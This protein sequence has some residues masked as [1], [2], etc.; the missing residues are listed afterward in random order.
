MKKIMI[1][2][3][4]LALLFVLLLAGGGVWA[5]SAFFH[6]EPLTETELAE[7]TPDW[8]AVTRGNWSPWYDAGD[9]TTE[10]NPV[11]SYNA[12]VASIPEGDRAWPALVDAYYAHFDLL[13]SEVIMECNGTVPTDPERWAL[14]EPVLATPESD[15]LLDKLLRAFDRPEMG[16]WLN[17]S[18]GPYEHAAMVK[19]AAAQP[20]PAPGERAFYQPGPLKFDREANNELIN[21]WMPWLSRQRHFANFMRSKAAYE[22]ERGDT[23]MFVET[24]TALLRSSDM[25]GDIP[26]YINQLVES[27]IENLTLGTIDWALL[28]HGD[29]FEASALQELDDA[30]RLHGDVQV[31]WQGEALQFN[32][33]LRRLGDASGKLAPGA[34]ANVGMGLGQPTSLPDAQLHASSQRALLVYNR[35]LKAASDHAGLDWDGTNGQIDALYQQQR[36]SLNSVTSVMLDILLPSLDR[37]SI[38]FRQSAQQTVGTRLAIAAYRHRLRHGSFPESLDAIDTDLIGFNPVD[39][40]TGEPLKYRIVDN[41]PLIYSVGDDRVDDNGLIR[42]RNKE[43]GELGDEKQIRVRTWPEWIPSAQ[44]AQQRRDAPETI[45]G[46]WV[47]F[48]MPVND[49]EP[50]VEREED[51]FDG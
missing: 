43:V 12:W 30:I 6:A 44:A 20:E 10:W 14:F 16:G 19:H 7:L 39:A 9:G 34:S 27:A 1:I 26:M 49:P 28:H 41:R 32:D 2:V 45:V 33:T 35:L 24:M 17:N 3:G 5:Y 47:L 23:E 18:D 46:D 29:Q 38:S 48:P 31:I 8:D 21:I 22:L 15:A 36:G 51:E 37:M 25:A 13:T 42:W 4:L 11:A 50:I 40:F